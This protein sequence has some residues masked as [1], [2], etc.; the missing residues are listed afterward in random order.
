MITHMFSSCAV[1][2]ILRNLCRTYPGAQI[3]ELRIR[4]ADISWHADIPWHVIVVGPVLGPL[5]RVG[6]SRKI[7]NRG[8]NHELGNMDSTRQTSQKSNRGRDVSGLQDAF[9]TAAVD[10][11][12]RAGRTHIE[13]LCI[14]FSGVDDSRA[15][16]AP[17]FL[18]TNADS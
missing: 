14:N 2:A 5:S 8:L 7:I 3:S 13:K 17:A 9:S 1:R 4:F 16:P 12:A 10:T 11:S 15:N 18:A 6:H